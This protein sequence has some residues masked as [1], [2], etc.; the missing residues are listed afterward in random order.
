LEARVYSDGYMDV[1]ADGSPYMV[2][3]LG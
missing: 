3:T 2:G 1:S